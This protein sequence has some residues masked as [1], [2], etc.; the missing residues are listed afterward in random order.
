NQMVGAVDIPKS[1]RLKLG[2][3]T[4]RTQ[5]SIPMLVE[6]IKRL[7]NAPIPADS[8]SALLRRPALAH[9]KT[10]CHLSNRLGPRLPAVL[11]ELLLMRYHRFSSGTKSAVKDLLFAH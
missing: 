7:V 6:L 4:R 11:R 3:Q 1:T 9:C 8:G 10:R 2:W 5:S